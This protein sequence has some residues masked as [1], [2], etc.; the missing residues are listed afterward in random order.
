MHAGVDDATGRK[1]YVTRTVR[2]GRREA[3]RALARLVTE[4]EQGSASAHA[5]TVGELCE[6]WFAASRSSWSPT[7]VAEYRR[8]L[9]RHVL[10]RFGTLPLR[11]LRTADLDAWY[12]QLRTSGSA[13]GGPLAPNSVQRVHAVLR[14]ALGQGVRWGWIQVNPASA[15]TPP[16]VLRSTVTIPSPA[17]IAALV[18]AAAKVNPAL[19]VFLR[20]AAVTGARRGELCALRWR[21]IDF[22]R[23]ALH[24]EGALVEA[25]GVL[26]EKDTKT[27]AERRM[28]LDERTLAVLAAHRAHLDAV[29]A[30]ARV[31]LAPD[32]FVFSHEPDG[33]Q[34]W[35]PNY[36][37]L[38]FGRLVKE[39]GLSGLRL[40]DLRHFAATA[41]LVSGIDVRTASG[42][43]GHANASTTLDVYA[44]FVKAADERA[45]SAV[46]SVLDV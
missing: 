14:R 35:R 11:R 12:G 29:L 22:E 5:G 6:R 23:S 21:H 36:A 28:S 44:H 25:G 26:I 38:A 20:L 37:T 46:A 9:D 15:A 45:A 31:S 18:D 40:H 41:M 13:T 19:P 4:V 8:L 1:R 32:A 34:P 16:R 24:I 30:V 17:T 7:V 39:Q 2:G 10:P 43:L 3:E 33:R 27:H 42:R